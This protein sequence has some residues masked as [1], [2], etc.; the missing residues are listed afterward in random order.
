VVKQVSPQ[1]A[2]DLLAAKPEFT[3]AELIEETGK[4]R[5]ELK[6]WLSTSPKTNLKNDKATPM[7]TQKSE[8]PAPVTETTAP[9]P[10][11]VANTG[12]V[13]NRVQKENLEVNLPESKPDPSSL[14]TNTVREVDAKTA[15]KQPIPSVR[16][17]DETFQRM[18]LDS[19]RVV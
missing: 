7:P 9:P 19:T 12:E 8:A 1:Y 2:K 18:L 15:S 14:V 5:N 17:M 10:V 13:L 4:T 6:E 11:E 3:D 16:N